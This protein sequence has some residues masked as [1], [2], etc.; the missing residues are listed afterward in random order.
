MTPYTPAGV[1]A[2]GNSTLNLP[3]QVFFGSTQAALGYWGLSPESVGLYQVNL[4]VPSVPVN[5]ATPLSF[6]LN[7]ASGAQTLYIAVGN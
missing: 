4:V 5:A 6:T 7:G 2:I 3:L 1:R